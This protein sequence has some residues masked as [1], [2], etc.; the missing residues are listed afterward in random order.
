MDK[1]ISFNNA[2]HLK[3]YACEHDIKSY[4]ME[5]GHCPTVEQKCDSKACPDLE[6][7]VCGSNGMTY[8]NECLFK[9]VKCENKLKITIAKQGTCDPKPETDDTQTG[10]DAAED[11]KDCNKPCSKELMPVCGSNNQTFNNECLL[12]NAQCKDASITEKHNGACD[13]KKS[14]K[15][16]KCQWHNLVVTT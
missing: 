1:K 14:N 6:N 7:P 13:P 15:A 5:D 2:C 11:D 8:R 10:N 9:K 12:K 4:L 16:S 3:K